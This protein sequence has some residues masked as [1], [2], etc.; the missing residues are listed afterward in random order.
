MLEKA[1]EFALENIDRIQEEFKR[2]KSDTD[3]LKGMLGK[4]GYEVVFEQVSVMN[5]VQKLL[6]LGDASAGSKKIRCHV[7][8]KDKK[9]PVVTTKAEVAEGDLPLKQL[10]EYLALAR[11]TKLIMGEGSVLNN[12]QN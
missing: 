11:A 5:G 7:I 2:V 12:E 6:I 9:D 1:E 3:Y 10:G 4:V 8:P